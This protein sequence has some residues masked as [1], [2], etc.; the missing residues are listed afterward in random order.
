M[1]L[2]STGLVVVLAT[3]AVGV[4]LLAAW[5]WSGRRRLPEGDRRRRALR[6]AGVFGSCVAAQVV[7]VFLVFVVVNDQYQF[8]ASFKDLIGA[9]GG[10]SPILVNQAADAHGGQ[11]ESI[12]IHGRASHTTERALVWLPPQYAE[13]RYRHHRFPVVEFLPG[14]PAYPGGM[15]SRFDL[16]GAAAAAIAHGAKP[17]VLVVPPIMV[18]PP[19]DTECTNVPHGPQALSWLTKDVPAAITSQLR[20]KHPGRHWSMIGWSTGGFCAAKVLLTDPHDYASAAVLGGYFKPITRGTVPHLFGGNPTLRR[21]NSPRWLYL[22]H[23]LRHDHLLLIAGRQDAETWPETSRMLRTT[24]G[25]RRVS[26]VAF[27][28]GGH[29]VGDYAAYL[30]VVFRWLTRT[31]VLA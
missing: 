2:L 27:P 11:L 21:H 8:Y 17:F 24:Q 5:W 30:P 9:T 13:Q 28:A 14:Q 18:R 22:H 31:G 12:T 26:F 20:V 1:N 29:N 15:V 25:D 16:G 6:A 4:P 7:A 19:E 23:G 3:L 10:T